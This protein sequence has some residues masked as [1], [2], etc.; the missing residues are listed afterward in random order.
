MFPSSEYRSRSET[1]ELTS[2]HPS[3]YVPNRQYRKAETIDFD[4]LIPKRE[5]LSPEGVLAKPIVYQ[6]FLCEFCNVSFPAAIPVSFGLV[7][8]ACPNCLKDKDVVYMTDIVA[9]EFERFEWRFEL[10]ETEKTLY[11]ELRNRLDGIQLEL[12]LD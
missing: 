7:S 8:V 5:K 2:D 1:F 6:R 11:S 9:E 3:S 4:E 12:D 10:T